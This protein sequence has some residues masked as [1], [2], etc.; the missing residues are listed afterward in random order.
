MVGVLPAAFSL[1]P[2][3]AYLSAGWLD[4][5]TGTRSERFAAAVN[6]YDA[7]PLVVRETG[8]FAVGNVATIKA[9]GIR[10]GQAFRIVNEP[11]PKLD[12]Y[13]A[14]RR[15][16]SDE[17]DLLA[18]LADEAWADCISVAACRTAAPQ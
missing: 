6:D 1:R 16:S 12:S 10:F 9:A 18:L 4:F 7:S 11:K 8:G 2:N 5:Y 14:V 15:Y 3:E 17:L 13:V